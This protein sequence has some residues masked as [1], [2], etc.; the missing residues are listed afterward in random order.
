MR[1]LREWLIIVIGVWL[2]GRIEVIIIIVV[3]VDGVFVFVLGVE[4]IL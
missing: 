2:V 3:V 1:V 4:I